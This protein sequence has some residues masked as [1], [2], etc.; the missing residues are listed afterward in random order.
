MKGS[1]LPLAGESSLAAGGFTLELILGE[2]PDSSRAESQC[3]RLLGMPCMIIM[4]VNSMQYLYT[5]HT[6]ISC[7]GT[8]YTS[9][10]AH[11]T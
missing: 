9:L 8:S 3:C 2:Q 5:D 4:S 7:I 6:H 1:V 11:C 10:I